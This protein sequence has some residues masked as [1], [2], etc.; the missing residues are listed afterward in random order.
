MCYNLYMVK[1]LLKV[2][3]ALFATIV[4]FA[5]SHLLILAVEAVMLRSLYPVNIFSIL[6]VD[7]YISQEFVAFP[8]G[9]IY[10]LIFMTI[11]FLGFFLW[12][13]RRT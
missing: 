5:V 2:K 9:D 10:S 13:K 11:V 12:Q 4:F 3:N 6:G 8:M 1:V 7:K